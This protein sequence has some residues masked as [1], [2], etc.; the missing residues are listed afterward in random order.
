MATTSNLLKHGMNLQPIMI[1]PVSSYLKLAG[2]GEAG[3]A[4]W[5]RFMGV[6]HNG[7]FMGQMASVLWRLVPVFASLYRTNDYD[8]DYKF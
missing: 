3:E 4:S 7:A 5:G 6:H 2:A 8:Y 1:I